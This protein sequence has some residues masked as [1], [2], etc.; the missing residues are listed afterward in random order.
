MQKEM[1]T[2]N[3]KEKDSLMELSAEDLRL[4]DWEP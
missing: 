4:L 3:L 1:I 2:Y